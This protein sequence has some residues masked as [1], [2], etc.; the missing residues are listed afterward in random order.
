M[1]EVLLADF[2]K[3]P[4]ISLPFVADQRKSIDWAAQG[5][6]P[7]ATSVLAGALPR[8]VEAVG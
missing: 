8:E 5:L 6:D 1:I 2:E 3:S 4:G 7:V